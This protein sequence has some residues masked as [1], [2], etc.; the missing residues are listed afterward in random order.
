MATEIPDNEIVELFKKSDQAFI[1]KNL[2]MVK[3]LVSNKF[4]YKVSFLKGV[5][6][7][8]EAL[9]Y[10]QYIKEIEG[11]FNS[12]ARIKKYMTDIIKTIPQNGKVLTKIKIKSVVEYETFVS[13]CVILSDYLLIR[14]NNQLLG[15]K[16][17]GIAEC[18]RYPTYSK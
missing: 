1:S 18:N 9:N 12:E 4:S 17:E 11:Y 14:E 8:A 13:D 2:E 6:H 16:F 15:L 10:D 3:S 7:E 5:P